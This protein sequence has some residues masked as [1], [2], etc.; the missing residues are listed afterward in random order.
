[1]L[2]DL[3]TLIHKQKCAIIGH[4]LLLK[5]IPPRITALETLHFARVLS[6]SKKNVK[7]N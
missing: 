6:H 7:T 1:M 5:S 4:L 2:E 3:T